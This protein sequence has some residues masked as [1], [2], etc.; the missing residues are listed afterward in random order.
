MSKV[1]IAGGTGMIGTLLCKMLLGENHEVV[2]LTTQKNA[3]NVP[4]GITCVFWNPEASFI[5]PAFKA[6]SCILINLAGASVADERWS[7]KR[8]KV[9]VHSRVQSLQTLYK[10]VESG[11][12]KATRLISASAIGYY[13]ESKKLLSENA[14]PDNSFLSL[15]CQQ[16]EQEAL[17]FRNLNVSTSIARIGIV[18]SPEG[19]AL[20]TFLNHWR[21]G[22]AAIPGNGKQMM[23]W[24]HIEDMCNMLIYLMNE[25]SQD[26]YN[27]VADYPVSANTLFKALFNNRKGIYLKIHVPSLLLKIGLGEM[28]AEIIKNGFIS[29]KKIREA[30]F[31]FKYKTIEPAIIDLLKTA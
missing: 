19:G 21:F 13:A 29:N 12:I 23:S 26:I 28:G 14:P 17:L 1:I 8:K 9:I 4:P 25:V 20:K 3:I 10:A 15:T 16:W 6:D 2:I 11:Q 31:D 5:D 18:L 30:G 24:I 22:I 27:A 7:D